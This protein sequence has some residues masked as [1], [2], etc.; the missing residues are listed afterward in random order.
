MSL[1]CGRYDTWGLP[2]GLHASW[3]N[4]ADSVSLAD[5]LPSHSS[6]SSARGRNAAGT[7]GPMA[8]ARALGRVR[9]APH[10]K[11]ADSDSL[12]Q[13]FLSF[14]GGAGMSSFLLH[15]LELSAPCTVVANLVTGGLFCVVR[16]C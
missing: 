8:F 9:A 6:V 2:E 7:P 16:W 10:A 13:T 15:C 4:E 5:I 14:C 11:S 12:N 3:L 1:Q